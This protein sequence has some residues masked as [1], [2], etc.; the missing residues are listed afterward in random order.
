M[1]INTKTSITWTNEGKDAFIQ[2]ML[3]E[4]DSGTFTDSGFKVDAWTRMRNKV[5]QVLGVEVTKQQLQSQHNYYRKLF[6]AFTE[7]MSTSGFGWDEATKQLR[8]EPVV[9]TR[10][11]ASHKDA[12]PIWKNDKRLPYHDELHAIFG[13]RAHATGRYAVAAV[14]APAPDS[15]D[16]VSED[17]PEQEEMQTP[18]RGEVPPAKRLKRS[19]PSEEGRQLLRQL[20]TQE[21]HG[22]TAM[23]LVSKYLTQQLTPI[24]T[25]RLKQ[26]FSTNENDAR[27]FLT[28][29]EEERSIFVATFEFVN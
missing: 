18:A 21:P 3:S 15:E 23:R 11:L 17:E 20:V 13:D 6:K 24:H 1:S 26:H 2:A 10:Y 29:T 14:A 27:L 22:M 7:L 28:L 16:L 12:V 5:S 8:A 4:I 25:Y 19:S 9:W